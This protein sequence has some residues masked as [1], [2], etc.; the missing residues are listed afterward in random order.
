MK[1]EDQSDQQRTNFQNSEGLGGCLPDKTAPL[2]DADYVRLSASDTEIIIYTK[3]GERPYIVHWGPRLAHSSAEELIALSNRQWAHGGP[4]MDIGQSLSNELATGVA[5]P[6]GFVAHR[7]GDDWATIFTV[8]HVRDD[9]GNQVRI[10]CSDLNTGLKAIYDIKLDPLSNVAL[11]TTSI[12]NDGDKPIN[13]DWC[14]ALCMPIDESLTTLKS[15]TGRWAMEFQEQAV[16][17]FRGSYV[18]E[19]KSGRTSHDNFPGLIAMSANASESSGRVVGLHLGWSGNNRVRMDRHSDGHNSVQ[20]G[21]LFHP[22][23][24]V[25]APGQSY[26]TPILY[27]AQSENG[28][29]DLSQKFHQCLNASVMD[30]RIA[31]KPRLVHYNTWEAVYFDHSEDRLTALAEKAAEVG[32]ERFVLDDGW[33][34]SRRSDQSGLGDWWVS[35]DVYPNGLEPLADKVRSLGME[36]GIWFEP[37][38]VNPDSD[39]FRAHPEWVLEAKGVE[40]IPSRQQYVLDLTRPEVS[41]YLYEKISKIVDDLGVT[42]IKWDMNRDIQHPGSGSTENAGRGAIHKQTKSVYAL[43]DRLRK[44]SPELE[45]ESC[46]SGG[47]RAD[48]GILRYTDRIWLSDSNDALDRQKIQRGAS[49]FFPP[50]VLGSHVGP[51]QCHITKRT[52]SMELRAATAIF[53]HMG[54]E[55]DLLS[56]SAEDLETLKQGIAIYKQHRNVLHN[57]KFYR[58]DTPDY[59]NVMGSVSL[60]QQAALFSCAKTDGHATTLPGRLQFPGLDKTRRYRLKI[61]WPV[62]DFVVTK[63]SIVDTLDLS[64]EGSVF[65][66][67]ALTVYGIQLPLLYPETCIIFALQSI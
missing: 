31:N 16:S 3:K 56:E 49:H 26:T 51:K 60:D 38:M 48:Y 4:A 45:I 11:A 21:E 53:G 39:L 7:Q 41:E 29:S 47:A 22:G 44:A 50:N 42:Y 35:K 23:E 14:V 2:I 17:I 18:R 1:P 63:P 25:L 46:S 64:D 65:S 43:I 67:E 52:L 5:G 36:F 30:G 33:F 59:L 15:F 20:M 57:G 8:E 58:L 10:I 13:I 54:M 37:E 9:I 19:N 62:S 66:G 55:L 32:A 24:M 61:I 12:S 40:Q 6:S 34:G 27:A 28:L